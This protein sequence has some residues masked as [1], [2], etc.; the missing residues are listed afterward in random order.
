M[1]DRV[2]TLD[3]KEIEVV[4]EGLRRSAAG[5]VTRSGFER[6]VAD[7]C[8][9]KVGPWYGW[10]VSPRHAVDAGVGPP[11]GPRLIYHNISSGQVLCLH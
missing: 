9:G 8:L 4:D 11:S 2:R 10:Y 1:W 3:W 6:M 7:V 5:T